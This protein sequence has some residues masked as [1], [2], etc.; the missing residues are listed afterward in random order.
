MTASPAEPSERGGTRSAPRIAPLGDAALTVVFGDQ[1]DPALGERVRRA[2]AAVRRGATD[3]IIPGV[4]DVVPAYAALVVHYDPLVARFP[5]MAALVGDAV[6]VARDADIA[7]APR[8]HE[9]PVRYDGPDLAD[10]ARRCGLAE[11]EVVSRH[12]GVEYRVELVGFVPGFGY[13]APLDP[14]LV[15][16]RRDR[17]RRSVPAGSVAIAG[18]QTGIYPFA[19]PG[20]WHLIGR[21]EAV[22][23]DAAR[24][25]P[26]LLRAGDRVRFVRIA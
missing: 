5:A 15:L 12:T 1:V 10:V 13:L 3:G 23:F 11:D 20:G 6:R 14:A 8:R 9:I 26:A 25:E 18:A 16:P 17:P 19:T 2:A 22:L 7:E 21:T 4:V 24:P